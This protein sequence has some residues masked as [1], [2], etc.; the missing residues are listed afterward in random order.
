MAPLHVATLRELPIAKYKIIFS[1]LPVSK[2]HYLVTALRLRATV[3]IVWPHE[4]EPW[5]HSWYKGRVRRDPR[6]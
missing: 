3:S 2:A 4:V 5:F 6:C 1:R